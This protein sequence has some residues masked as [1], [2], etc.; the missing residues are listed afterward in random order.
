MRTSG[1]PRIA[2]D[3]GVFE[4][5]EDL[6]HVVNDLLMAV[7]FYVV[8]LEV[9]REVAVRVAARPRARRRCPIAAALGTMVGA[10]LTYVAIN[11]DGGQLGG[12]AIPIATDI[13]FAVGVL[14]LAGRR[15]PPDLRAFLLT[16]ASWT[17]SG[18]LR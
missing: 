15:A 14:G 7:F 16:L 6:R 9:K 17:T 2:L 12:W 11:L 8:A 13:A 5:E 18:R 3:L 1:R 4:F 10:A